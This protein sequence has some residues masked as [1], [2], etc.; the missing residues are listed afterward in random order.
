MTS[1]DSGALGSS[2]HAVQSSPNSS[3][4]CG[5]RIVPF[6]Q[7]RSW[8]EQ[9]LS[10]PQQIRSGCFGLSAIFGISI[11]PSTV[12]Q[13]PPLTLQLAQRG[14]VLSQFHCPEIATLVIAN[15][16]IANMDELALEVNPE[17]GNVLTA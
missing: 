12:L 15:R 5:V 3:T 4:G 16:K 2:S 6:P 17:F 8:A 7:R 9:Y 13:E 1:R 14:N 10:Q 11:V